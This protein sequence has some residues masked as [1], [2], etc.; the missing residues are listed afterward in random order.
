MYENLN[1]KKPEDET[2]E[3][4]VIKSFIYK[5]TTFFFS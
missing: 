5:C 2:V 1:F 4:I 3:T